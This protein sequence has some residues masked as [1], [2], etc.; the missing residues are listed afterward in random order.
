MINKTNAK[1]NHFQDK[2]L[3]GDV[4]IKQN[5][6]RHKPTNIVFE[7]WLCDLSIEELFILRMFLIFTSRS[8]QEAY[9]H[10]SSPAKLIVSSIEK[11]LKSHSTT[12][13]ETD[14]IG[15]F[16]KARPTSQVLYICSKLVLKSGQFLAP[17][18]QIRNKNSRL[19]LFAIPLQDELT[20][21]G[22]FFNNNTSLEQAIN[23]YQYCINKASSAK[24]YTQLK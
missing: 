6:R 22:I 24:Q 18:F 7:N 5:S 20:Y 2:K 4:I 8:N 1:A 16:N 23:A 13:I 19:S 21:Y 14:I 9:S 12:C 17:N 11:W 10:L 15:Y 3:K